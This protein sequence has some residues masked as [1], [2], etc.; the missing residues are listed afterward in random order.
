M[1]LIIMTAQDKSSTKSTK[2]AAAMAWMKSGGLL[3][4]RSRLENKLGQIDSGQPGMFSLSGGIWRA[5]ARG[6]LRCG[7]EG[8]R[9]LRVCRAAAS[10]ATARLARPPAAP[11]RATQVP[12]RA[13]EH[14]AHRDQ[15]PF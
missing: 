15:L 9:S 11:E 3:A 2:K 14:E 12:S 13:G 7:D 4:K 5:Q 8:D 6:Q 10:A 1:S